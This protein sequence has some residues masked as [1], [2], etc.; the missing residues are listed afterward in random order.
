MRDDPVLNEDKIGFMV[1]DG[2]AFYAQ[3]FEGDNIFRQRVLEMREPAI[4]I[5]GSFNF[6]PMIAHIAFNK[7]LEEV[8]KLVDY[9]RDKW[10]K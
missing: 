9:A 10:G 5:N 1:C 7:P 6:D 2:E 3:Y 8:N 4:E